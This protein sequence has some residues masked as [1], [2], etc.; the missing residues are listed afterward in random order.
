MTPYQA[1][2]EDYAAELVAKLSEAWSLAHESIKQA[3][4]LQKLQYDKKIKEP[5]YTV[6]RVMVHHP[7][8]VCGEAWKLAPPYFGP[9]EILALT[10]TNAEVKPLQPL[11]AKSIFRG[12]LWQPLYCFHL[13]FRC[14][15]LVRYIYIYIYIYII[16]I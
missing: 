5:N 10:P 9:Y 12:C 6:G 8:N 13:D 14:V 2:F 15:T 16:W 1:E 11:G 4:H 3:Q 7:G